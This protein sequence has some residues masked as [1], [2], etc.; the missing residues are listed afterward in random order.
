MLVR[1]SLCSLLLVALAVP[2]AHAQAP[3]PSALYA[4]DERQPVQI[5]VGGVY[6]TYSNDDEEITEFSIPL[7]L[8]LPFGDNIALSLQTNYATV[9]VSEDGEEV[10]TVSG[11][12]D[13]QAIASYFQPVGAASLVF[14]LGVN[15]TTGNSALAFDE[16]QTLTI[17]GQTAYDLRVPTFGQ[18][19]RVV[20]A[21][22]Y[23][24]PVGERVALGLGASY[25]YRGPYEPLEDLPDAY[26]PGEEVLLT[27]GADLEITPTS[28]VSVDASFGLTGDDE[29]GTEGNMRV[30]EPGNTV[31]VTGQYLLLW[32]FHELR[33]VARYRAR[34]TASFP[35]SPVNAETAVPNQIQFLTDGRFELSPTFD[36]GA[37]ARVRLFGE[38][39]IFGEPLTLVDLGLFPAFMATERLGLTGQFVYTLGSFSGFTAGAG[40]R[41]AL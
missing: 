2:V 39:A 15:A 22:T 7:S 10:A 40:L 33:A 37:R 6:Q 18:G 32:G 19:L 41:L 17:A 14:S 28:S 36:L 23:A 21:V 16:Y 13:V 30:Y 29:F 3:S 20:P 5:S 9:D 11:I 25:Q 35:D 26:D 24:F 12:A 4:D 38:S 1:R 27:A 34:G 8:R 31:A